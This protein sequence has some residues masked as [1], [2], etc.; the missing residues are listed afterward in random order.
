MDSAGGV[1]VF[2]LIIAVAVPLWVWYFN[3]SR[4]L[5]SE[6]ASYNRLTLVSVE[7]K[8]FW[9]GPFWWR[10][11]KGQ[12]VFR[13]TVRDEAGRRRSGY[14]RVGGFWSGLLCDQ[15]TVVWD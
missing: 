14:V 1:I 13:V 7:R 8:L 15:V 11:G 5:V 6:W 3:R 4:E 2:I 9:L 12:A 10:T